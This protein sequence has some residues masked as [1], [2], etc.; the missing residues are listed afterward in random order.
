[1]LI[2][3]PFVKMP[4]ETAYIII[5]FIYLITFPPHVSS[6]MEFKVLRGGLLSRHGPDPDLHS[7][8][9]VVDSGAFLG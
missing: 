6:I 7:F 8:R 9:M 4:S 5:E 2:T 1:M 3:A